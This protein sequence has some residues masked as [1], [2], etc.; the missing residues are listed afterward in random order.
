M[1]RLISGKQIPSKVYFVMVDNDALKGNKIKNPYNFKHF[2]LERYE[3]NV[4]DRRN[5]TCAYKLDFDK[6]GTLTPAYLALLEASGQDKQDGLG[7]LITDD[8]FAK[9]TMIIEVDLTSTMDQN[10]DVVNLTSTGDL[11]LSLTFKSA[12]NGATLLMLAHYNDHN[13]EIAQ[14]GEVN[15]SW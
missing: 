11:N 7:S 15:T 8:R 3:V 13:I 2:H 12:P 4:G 14:P 1:L 10:E 5:P 9:G 6:P